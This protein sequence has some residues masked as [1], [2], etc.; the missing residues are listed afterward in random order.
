MTDLSRTDELAL[1]AGGDAGPPCAVAAD[2]HSVF[3]G[4]RAAVSGHEIVA[5]N[6]QGTV[7]WGHHHGPG[8]SGVR[9]LAASDGVVFVLASGESDESAGSF[10]YKLDARSGRPVPWEGRTEPE[11]QLTSLWPADAEVKPS[12]GTSIA[13]KNGRVYVTFGKEEFI[14]ALD[15]RS[16]AYVIT[17]NG[18]APTQMALSITPMTDP[19]DP[20]K[21]RVIDFGVCALAGNGIAYFVMEHDPAWVMA[22]T[23]RWLQEDERIVAIALTGDTMKSGDATIY[24]ALADP[25]HQVQLR[26]VD[27][28]E[29]FT[30]AV[31]KPGGRP[32]TGAWEADGLRDIRA[33][34]IDAQ[35]QLW[36]AEGDANFGRF[37]VWGTGEKQGK[38]L[39]EYFGPVQ[40][41]P[42]ADLT[43]PLKVTTRDLQWE[44]DASTRRAALLSRRAKPIEPPPGL[45]E[46]RD[47]GGLL[48]WSPHESVRDPRLASGK[49]RI[50]RGP[51]A[52][53]YAG[54]SM[55]FAT[56]V[57]SLRGLESARML[58][59]G[60]VTIPA[61]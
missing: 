52:Q 3:L 28:A 33:I 30:V 40:A 51:D 46:L 6:P 1:V 55:P 27:N 21:S 23:T 5:V 59:S 10:I 22:S 42:L 7:L 25:H 54:C 17:L 41:E 43:N 14:A 4:W 57:F 18:P 58:G 37:S 56:H 8:K 16:G 19:Q 26:T 31:G 2:E 44:I 24:T 32:A 34:A 49:W 13:A 38:L 61:R 60:G 50:W 47:E 53:V 15:G 35:G 11:I 36:V 9:A 20:G 12:Q 29:S 48:L 39:R 45:G